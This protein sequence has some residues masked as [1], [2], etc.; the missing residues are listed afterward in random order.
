M[1]SAGR[2]F[3]DLIIRQEHPSTVE[4]QL[5]LIRRRIEAMGRAADRAYP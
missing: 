5:Q 4:M 2:R 3:A 1:E